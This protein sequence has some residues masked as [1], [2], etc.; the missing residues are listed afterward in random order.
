MGGLITRRHITSVLKSPYRWLRQTATAMLFENRYGVRTSDVVGL[1]ELGI[2]DPER[3]RYKASPWLVL[4]RIL[5]KREVCRHDVFLDLGSGM[6]R[7]VLQATQ[8]PFRRV[9]G[10]E[11]SEELTR[12]ARQ[13]VSR[14][15]SRQRC[16]SV[17]LVCADVVHYEISDD[18][19]VVFL[20]N[21]FA[22]SI[23]DHV[24]HALL[25]SVDRIPRTVR[26]IYFNPVEEAKLLETGRVRLVRALRGMR[27]TA[28]WSR[29]N[30]ARMYV[31]EPKN[32]GER[33]DG[34][35]DQQKYR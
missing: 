6:G 15:V 13:N 7:V 3:Q 10:V 1:D 31:L 17:S 14:N 24:V 32:W 28:E 20:G 8:Y 9:I 33:A 35:A 11:L 4:R 18:V 23:F 25:E 5:P 2:A 22:G 34:S 30:A 27:P 16:G 12:I 21:P 29:S 26:I 19:T